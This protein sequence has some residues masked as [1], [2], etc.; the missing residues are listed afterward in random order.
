M[1]ETEPLRSMVD[2]MINVWGEFH[3]TGSFNSTLISWREEMNFD[4]FNVI[5]QFE[6]SQRPIQN[7]D[8]CRIL[9]K[10]HEA[11]NELILGAIR[12]FPKM[13]LIS[14]KTKAFGP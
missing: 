5:S 10:D 7:W 3:K 14:H 11:L 2:K 12:V 4:G 8:E 9:D 13:D 1:I 6:W